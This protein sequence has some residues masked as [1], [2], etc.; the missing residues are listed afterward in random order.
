MIRK[1]AEI[2]CWKNV[3]SFS[4]FFSKKNIRIFYI[5]SAK[6]VNEMT[7]N[8]FV[9]LTTLWTT[10]LW[11]IFFFIKSTVFQ[12]W[13]GRWEVYPITLGGLDTLGMFSRHFRNETIIVTFCL[14]AACNSPSKKRSAMKF[15]REPF[16]K[17]RQNNF[18]VYHFS[19]NKLNFL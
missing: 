14:L 5:E 6:T 9:K 11:C 1:Y 8:D 12:T 18:W 17:L 16:S 19:L 4:H 13:C 15:Y 7:L 2:F 10:G 3:S